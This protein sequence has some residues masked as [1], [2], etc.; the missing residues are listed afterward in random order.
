MICGILCLRQKDVKIFLKDK[1]LK[2][3]FCKALVEDMLKITEEWKNW[4]GPP[5]RKTR[6]TNENINV[7][8]T[9]FP[10]LLKLSKK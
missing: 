8:A 9:N 7:W 6:K 10:H 3:C 1:C 5:Q 2:S 4:F